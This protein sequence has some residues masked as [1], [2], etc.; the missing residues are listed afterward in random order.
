LF[1]VER[2]VAL[3]ERVM[4]GADEVDRLATAG[5]ELPRAGIV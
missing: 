4:L 5:G 1:S 3:Y 2:A